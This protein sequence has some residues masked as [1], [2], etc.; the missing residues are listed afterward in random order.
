MQL[1][2][3]ENEKIAYNMENKYVKGTFIRRVMYVFT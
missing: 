3:H 1:W 2:M